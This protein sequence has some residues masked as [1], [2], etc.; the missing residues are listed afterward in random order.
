MLHII[1]PIPENQLSSSADRP[2]KSNI[3][4]LLVHV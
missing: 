3:D 2:L 4:T 1:F